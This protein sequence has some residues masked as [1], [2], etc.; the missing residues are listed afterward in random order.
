MRSLL[1]S[2]RIRQF[3]CPNLSE[4]FPLLFRCFRLREFLEARIIPERIEHRSGGP[5]K[6]QKRSNRIFLPLR[7]HAIVLQ[8][9]SR[10]LGLVRSF[11]AADWCKMERDVYASTSNRSLFSASMIFCISAICSCF[12]V[13]S[14]AETDA[15]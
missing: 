1:D 7:A 12:V 9:Q 11:F 4:K 8:R 5:P 13:A 3:L 2:R 15:R 14:E 6:A 10:N